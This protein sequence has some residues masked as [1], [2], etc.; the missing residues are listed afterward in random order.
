MTPQ[1]L[2][3]AMPFDPVAQPAPH[4]TAPTE[5]ACGDLLSA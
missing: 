2:G 1:R 3:A 4:P 5:S